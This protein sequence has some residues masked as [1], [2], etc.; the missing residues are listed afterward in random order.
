M[1]APRIRYEDLIDVAKLQALL[2]SFYQVIGIANAVIDIDGVIIAQAGWQDACTQFY[3]VNPQ[4]GRR[5]IESDTSLAESMTRGVPYA[6]YNCL[7]GLVDTAAPIM[8][9]G[10]H[11]A[12]VFTGQFLTAAPDLALF[13]CQAREFGF[14]EE[15][16]L[17][18]IARVPVVPQERVEAITRLYA[19]LAGMLADGGLDRLKQQQI[20]AELEKNRMLLDASQKLAHVGGWEWDI[21]RQAMM[22]T[23]EVYRIHGMNPDEFSAGSPEHIER[24][25][26]CFD[27]SDRSVIEIAFRRC[28]EDGITYDWELPLTRVDKRRIWARATAEAVRE[29][30]RIVKVIGSFQDITDRKHLEALRDESAAKVRTILDSLEGAVYVADMNSYEILYINEALKNLVGDVVGQ[31]CWQ[32]LQLGMTGPCH[33]CTNAR[34]VQP[35]GSP[36]E[37]VVWEHFNAVIGRWFQ[38]R[39]KAIPWPDGRLVR[40]EMAID[41]TARKEAEQQQ[42]KDAER[43]ELALAGAE[44]GTWESSLVTGAASYDR[45]WCAMLGYT[46]AEVT[47]TIDGWLALM[48]PEDRIRVQADFQ[49]NFEAHLDHYEAEFRLRHKDGHWVWIYAR[50]KIFRDAAGTPTHAAGTHLD[51]TDRKRLKTEGANLL[52]QIEEMIHAFRDHPGQSTTDGASANPSIEKLLSR[53]QIEV[54]KLIASGMTSAKIAE[55]LGISR[56]TVVDHRRELMRK[57]GA[58]NTADITRFALEQQLITR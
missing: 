37:P 31:T 41:I 27:P 8:V 4:T 11:V 21:V 36:A 3:R 19:Q 22:W 56:D 29:G 26:A 15:S 47:Q 9:G 2:N 10:Q 14:D 48:H 28:A 7:N 51:I 5:C 18:A 6:V 1:N 55:C 24:S 57:I 17:A 53:R 44:L 32:S 49:R 12:N 34:L 54:L 25:L 45:R 42:Q 46:V 20:N 33:F 40:I 23:D 52:R 13:S 38:C 58:H 50:G 43:L 35:D 30:G 39:D 16:Y